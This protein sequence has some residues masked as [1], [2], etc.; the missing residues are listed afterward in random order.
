MQ[1]TAAKQKGWTL[2]SDTND[3]Y[4]PAPKL[5]GLTVLSI[6]GTYQSNKQVE[7]TTLKV[8]R[9]V[10]LNTGCQS[11]SLCLLDLKLI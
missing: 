2:K 4:N 9:K 7:R 11:V 6:L 8:C 3:F 5:F 1:T 10:F